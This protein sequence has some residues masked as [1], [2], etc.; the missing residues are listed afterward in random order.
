MQPTQITPPAARKLWAPNFPLRPDRCPVFY[1]W[2]I[3]IFSTLGMC[4]SM[5]GQTVGISVFTTRLSA[6]LGLS[7]M[8]LSLTYM[9]GTLLS[10]IG[11]NAGGRFFDRYGARQALV[12]AIILLGLVLIALSFVEQ[13]SAAVAMI[14]LLNRLPWLPPFLVLTIG[15]ACLRFTGQGMLTLGSRAMIGKWFD[16]RR[17]TVT[18]V[19]GAMVSFAFSGAPLVFEYLIRNY[20]WQGAWRLL[21]AGFIIALVPLFWAFT[22]DNPEECGL[23][24]DGGV[25]GKSRRANPDSTIY[26]DYTLNEARR[27]FSFWAFTMVFALNAM[28]I[29]GYAFHII[30]IGA[31]LQVGTD[32]ILSLFIPAAAGAVLTGFATGW[33]TDQPFVRIKYLLCIMAVS[34]MLGFSALAMGNYPAISWLHIVG[35]GISGGCFG[36]LSSVVYPRFFGRQHLGAISGQFMT[37]IVI[38]S[39]GGPLLLSLSEAYLGSYR[40]GF[41][42]ASVVA[43]ALAIGALRAENPQRRTK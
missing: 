37:I 30:A 21:G 18:A 33:L 25:S 32:Y 9:L 28:V 29:T 14:P 41:W 39:A 5:P 17:G 13:L 23:E 11:I 15:F 7:T 36:S 42:I 19:S 10:A 16:K 1:G 24:M 20:S 4:A 40:A 3:V 6:A 34:S 2:V 12:S 35:F 38:A 22:R 27:T 8:E 31:E 43:A 26:R